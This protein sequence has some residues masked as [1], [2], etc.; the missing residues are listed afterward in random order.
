M[1]FYTSA[2][3][4]GDKILVRGYENGRPYNRRIEFNP[5][6]Y[7]NSKNPSKWKTLDGQ[8][9]EEVKPGSIRD[10]R[11]FVKRYDGVVGFNVYGNTNYVYQYLSDTYEDD[12][13]WD[14]EQFKVF[15]IDIETKVENGFPNIITANSVS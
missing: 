14:M 1:E 2:H 9:V 4:V 3:S 5:T 6:M 13:H 12:V 10:T 7:V 15:T 11:D 8:Y